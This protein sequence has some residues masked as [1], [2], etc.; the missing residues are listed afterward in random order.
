M[1]HQNVRQIPPISN[2]NMLLLYLLYVQKTH[3]DHSLL[4]PV[5][6]LHDSYCR[7]TKSSAEWVVQ[8]SSTY[9]CLQI[10]TETFQY[11]WSKN[12]NF[13]WDFISYR[14]AKV[15]RNWFHMVFL[16][17]L[18]NGFQVQHLAGLTDYIP[19]L[20]FRRQLEVPY[21]YTLD[22]ERH[23]I[24]V[25]SMTCPIIGSGRYSYLFPRHLF[26]PLLRSPLRT[27]SWNT[28]VS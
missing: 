16:C 1:S 24:L 21:C 11:Q 10:D 4:F 18:A 26:P 27:S 7:F 13:S 14:N 22:R 15:D 9:P 25:W 3:I 19:F 12:S 2:L 28:G 5:P 17:A 8:Y 23:W 6:L 20:V